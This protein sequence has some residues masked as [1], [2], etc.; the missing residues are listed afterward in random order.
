MCP[1][2]INIKELDKKLYL[3]LNKI[4]VNELAEQT[5]VK[6]G[7]TAA[8]WEVERVGEVGSF[9][10][11]LVNYNGK[12]AMYL[13]DGTKAHKIRPKNKKFLRFEM[14]KNGNPDSPKFR[15]PGMQEEYNKKGKVFIYGRGKELRAI[16]QKEGSKHFIMVKEVNHPGTLGLH[17]IEEVIGNQVIWDKIKREI[18]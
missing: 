1:S 5:P 4:L 18:L 8:N 10:Y 16:F 6:S 12:V 9:K 3:A 7:N 17:F 2:T 13:N 15:T 14:T 11:E